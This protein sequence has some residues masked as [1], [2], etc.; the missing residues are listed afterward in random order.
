M[1]KIAILNEADGIIRFED[2]VAE[3][4]VP[5][6]PWAQAEDGWQVGG[7]VA[8][9]EYTA[10]PEPPPVVPASVTR[11]QILTGLALVG[12]ITE[13]EALD[14]LATGARPVAVDAVIGQLPE[15]DRF[16]ATMK[17]IGFQTAYR[18]DAMVAA[19]ATAA[20]K[21]EQDVDDFFRLCAGIE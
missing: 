18:D 11:R 10:P 14:A 6:E 3:G 7:T 21:T 4:Y 16:A 17:W 15:A 8:E 5:N 20:G 9:G 12:W 1:M 19:L 13:Q 2:I